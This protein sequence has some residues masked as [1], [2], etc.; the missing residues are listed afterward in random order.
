M[1]SFFDKMTSEE[2][3]KIDQVLMR[4]KSI[5]L[6]CR[7]QQGKI[8]FGS[9]FLNDGDCHAVCLT[10]ILRASLR[11]RTSVGKNICAEKNQWVTS[12]SS[13]EMGKYMRW[14]NKFY[15]NILTH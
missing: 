2:Q 9:K 3:E 11:I 1:A 8:H 6:E 4:E 14:N 15:S 7:C 10:D 12:G 5:L 13:Y